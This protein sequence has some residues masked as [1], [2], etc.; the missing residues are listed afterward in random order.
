M[1]NDIPYSPK[2]TNP[3]EL[4]YDVFIANMRY[5][6][7]P[8]ILFNILFSSFATGGQVFSFKRDW[9]LS[10]KTILQIIK[11]AVFLLKR[12]VAIIIKGGIIAKFYSK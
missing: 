12:G 8:K 2:G 9:Y 7:R 1:S 6:L 10:L 3:S 11:L 4:I 5:T